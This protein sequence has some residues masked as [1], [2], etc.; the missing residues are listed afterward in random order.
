MTQIDKNFI[1]SAD[2]IVALINSHKDMSY[3]DLNALDSM[4]K[5]ILDDTPVDVII[6]DTQLAN[7]IA[8]MKDMVHDHRSE[9][10]DKTLVHRV[11][12][13]IIHIINHKRLYR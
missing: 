9:F 8:S 2:S 11:I 1:N 7:G 5:N 13:D 6:G 10:L 4:V 3:K 12:S